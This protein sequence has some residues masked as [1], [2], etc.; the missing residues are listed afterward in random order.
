MLCQIVRCVYVMCRRRRAAWQRGDKEES[1]QIRQA[2]KSNNN[3]A[4]S[5]VTHKAAHTPRCTRTNTHTHTQRQ[6]HTRIEAHTHIECPA[7]WHSC[8]TF[9]LNLMPPGTHIHSH[10]HTH[11]QAQTSYCHSNWLCCILLGAGAAQKWQ[12]LPPHLLLP[13]CMHST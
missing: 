8:A 1:G 4:N 13:F 12:N 3:K 9:K 11:A 5:H 6:R 2:K 7:H 10:S